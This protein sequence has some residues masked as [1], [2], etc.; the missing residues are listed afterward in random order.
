M[1][2]SKDTVT[3]VVGGTS[4]ESVTE[5]PVAS[6][7]VTVKYPGFSPVIVFVFSFVSHKIVY[8]GVPIG[9]TVADHQFF[10][11]KGTLSKL[12]VISVSGTK[13]SSTNSHPFKSVTLTSYN[14]VVKFVSL[15]V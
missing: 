7:T 11:Y 1:V 3:T 2:T 6:V 4:T 8:G 14:P 13:I 5:H 15:L 12:N 10:H 9:F